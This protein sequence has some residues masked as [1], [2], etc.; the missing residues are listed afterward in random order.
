M[1]SSDVSGRSGI[2][3]SERFDLSLMRRNCSQR[4]KA[5]AFSTVAQH[6]LQCLFTHTPFFTTGMRA[7]KSSESVDMVSDGHA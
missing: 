6:K 1:Y 3:G 4:L 5:C 7:Q 2:Q